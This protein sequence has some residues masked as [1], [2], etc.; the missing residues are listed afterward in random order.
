MDTRGPLDGEEAIC[1]VFSCQ[2]RGKT[3]FPSVHPTHG[4]FLHTGTQTA[5]ELGNR[6]ICHL[7]HVFV[8]TRET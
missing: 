4:E 7:S 5:M 1:R 6:V 3:Y 8:D 2:H